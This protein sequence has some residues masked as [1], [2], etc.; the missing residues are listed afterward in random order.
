MTLRD[1][2]LSNSFLECQGNIFYQR[3]LRKDNPFEQAYF[4]LRSSENRVLPD[5]VVK[6]LPEVDESHP[7]KKE[8]QMRKSSLD[9]LLESLKVDG[10]K[11]ILE[12]GCGNGWLSHQIASDLKI[13]VCG[14]DVNDIELV[15][16]GKVFSD[17]KNLVF[18]YAD[19][20]GPGFQSNM[21]DTVVLGGSVQYF[22]N[23]KTLLHRLF[24]LLVADGRIYIVDSPLYRSKL[25]AEKARRRS[26]G[27]FDSLN[28]SSMADRYF[29]HTFDDLKQFEY[30]LVYDPK[31]LIPRLK[32]R[33]LGVSLSIFPLV[34]IRKDESRSSDR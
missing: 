1:Q 32:R 9:L 6:R 2:F 30:K 20:F 33:V 17:N 34:C 26:I 7:N 3:N 24:D 5:D 14:V 18:A 29:H 31:S 22:P 27:H 4:K 25:E 19:I 12:L 13:Q 16:A 21:F 8:W 15:Q 10:A 11:T 23:L 28:I